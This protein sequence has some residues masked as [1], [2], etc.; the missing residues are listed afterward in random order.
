MSLSLQIIYNLLLG[1]QSRCFYIDR[2]DVLAMRL[3]P[4]ELGAALAWW[5]AELGLDKDLL[6]AILLLL[7]CVVYIGQVLETDAVGDHL[8]GCDF[9]VLDHLAKLLPV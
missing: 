7:E 6:H 1:E 2:C 9:L 8:H 4:L 5:E 3:K